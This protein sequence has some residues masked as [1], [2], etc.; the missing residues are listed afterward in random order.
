MTRRHKIRI[1]AHKNPIEKDGRPRGASS[2]AAHGD[3]DSFF[4]SWKSDA[5]TDKALGEQ[6]KIDRKLWR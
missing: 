4:G 3:L 5:K 2:T 6:R 1:L